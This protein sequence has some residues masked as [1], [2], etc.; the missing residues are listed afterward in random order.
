MANHS[1]LRPQTPVTALCASAY[2]IPTDAPEADGT[3]A[4]DA[5]TLVLV[6]VIAGGATG[7]GYTYSDA[8]NVA[9]I[10]HTL[11]ACVLGHD[12]FEIRAHWQRM[13]R[14][15]RNLG[16]SGLAAT[17]VSAIDCALWD[18]KARLLDMPLVALLG[19][20]RECVPLYGSGGFTS[21]TDARLQE[22][23]ASW[24]ERDGCRWVKMKVGSEPLRD[25]QRVE[26]ARK[27]IGED[28]G[29][30]VDANGALS[31]REAIKCAH[32]FAEQNVQWFEEPV[33]SDDTNGLAF[34]REHAPPCMDVAAGEY[35]YTLDDFLY[36]LAAPSVDV[37]QADASRCGG[38]TGFLQAAAL[39]DA[40]HVPLSAHCAP[41]LHL[42]AACAAPRLRHQEW[43]HDHV[44][45]EA[46]LFDGAPQARDGAI[47]PDLSRP[48]CGLEFKHSDAARYLVAQTAEPGKSNQ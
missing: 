11:A 1:T 29:L 9:L 44:R 3:L 22:Q 34:V 41:A 45:I 19:A 4:W 8:S 13:Q 38:I 37:L 40:R 2:R 10:Q 16:R 30:F 28:A 47:S 20:A 23:L 6:E 42:H 43:F 21:Y 25:P 15:V 24:I 33:S 36:L 48:G 46:M 27:A 31:A 35:G 18:L 14:Q 26:A 39:C 32:R 12:V 7:I 17:A 5:T